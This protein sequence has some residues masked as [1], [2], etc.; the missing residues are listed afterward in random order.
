M[1]KSSQLHLAAL[2]AVSGEQDL[3]TALELIARELYRDPRRYGLS[4]EDD[5][6]EIF[7]RY[8]ERLARLVTRFEDRGV[9]FEAYLRSATRY[10][11]LSLR[12]RGARSADF[13][14]IGETEA[15]FTLE[16]LDSDASNGTEVW[17]CAERP[18]SG[19]R[20]AAI[21]PTRSNRSLATRAGYL[22][23]K[24]APWLDDARIERYAR[25]SGMSVDL[26]AAAVLAAR[27]CGDRARAR[28]ERRARLRDASWARYSCLERR[29]LR[30]EDPTRRLMLSER[31]ARERERFE[32]ALA[33][34]RSTRTQLPNRHVATLLGVPKGTVDAG[35]ARVK[36][37][38]PGLPEDGAF[39]LESGS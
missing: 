36:R 37:A 28:L 7:C 6:G 19:G 13:E 34:V 26:L 14:A 24:C 11:A 38:A 22:C 31:L 35:I 15:G 30:E 10:F 4:G 2:R 20:V 18:P 8:G 32:K 33:L 5:V 12:R 9:P 21:R 29:F 23:L 39:P 17:M 1:E 27:S 25:R 16:S 3:R